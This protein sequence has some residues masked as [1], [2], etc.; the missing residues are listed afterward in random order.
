MSPDD[1]EKVVE[2]FITVAGNT[3]LVLVNTRGPFLTSLVCPHNLLDRLPSFVLLEEFQC[4][5]LG[6][7]QLLGLPLALLLHP[8]VERLQGQ[9][10][11]GEGSVSQREQARYVGG[12]VTGESSIIINIENIMT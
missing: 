8:D 9:P 5:V 12:V 7:L 2:I 10:G 4:V 1:G 11:A 6:L 3:P